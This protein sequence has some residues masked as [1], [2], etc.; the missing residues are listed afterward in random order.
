MDAMPEN[1]E[2]QPCPKC[3]SEHLHRSRSRGLKERSAKI[4][5]ARKFRCHECGF[6]CFRVGNSILIMSDL[7]R[8]ARTI[9]GYLAAIAGVAGC[10]Y[11]VRWIVLSLDY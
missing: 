5:G 4:V 6:T 1:K 3:N 10:I 9:G 8:A 2:G 7:A 11:A